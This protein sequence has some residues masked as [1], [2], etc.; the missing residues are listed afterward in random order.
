MKNESFINTNKQA[1]E[2]MGKARK[3]SIEYITRTVHEHGGSIEMDEEEMIAIIYD[4]GNHP[5]YASNLCSLLYS[6]YIDKKAGLCLHIEDDPCY[7][8]DRVYDIDVLTIAE[9]LYNMENNEEE[10]Q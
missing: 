5:E 10:Q 9:I 1:Y 4:G 7:G 3:E 8:I 2:A 6:V